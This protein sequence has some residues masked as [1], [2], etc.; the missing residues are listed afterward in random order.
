MFKNLN[1]TYTVRK[2]KARA[3]GE[4]PIYMRINVSGSIKEISTGE[5]ILPEK[6]DSSHSQVRGKGSRAK[7]INARLKAIYFKTME[8]HSQLL[9]EGADITAESVKARL[10]GKDKQKKMVPVMEVFT[11]HNAQM[12]KQIGN[13]Y[14]EST[15]K[16][17]RTCKKHINA[18]LEETYG[19]VRYP[20]S[21]VDQSF[22]EEFAD[23]LMSKDDPCSNNSTKK[24]LTNFQKVVN[25]ARRRKLLDDNPFENFK[26]KYNKRNPT[27][28][29]K[30]EVDRI[31]KKEFEI[32]RLEKVKDVFI[33]SCY[34]GFAYCDIERLKRINIHTDNNGIKYIQE[35]RTKTHQNAIVPLLPVPLAI[36]EKY[37][38]DPE[39]QDGNLLPVISNQKTNAYLKEIANICG[40]EKRLTFHV[41][42][43]TCGTLLL[44]EGM[45]IESVSKIL[46]HADLRMTQHYAKLSQTKINADMARIREKL[47]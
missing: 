35:A 10:T 27:F 17:Y 14:S 23:Y 9:Q 18:F 29:T 40:V 38:D 19:D 39:T 32:E 15:F 16:K 25:L 13:T 11:E 34:T 44:N 33:F 8:A 1:I 7:I 30:E 12:K 46:G 5:K 37:K 22:L 45:P 4:V 20:I 2:N 21:E 24:Y 36:I 3:N 26:M 28:L 31:Y 42:R 43:H 6:W 41:A 47:S